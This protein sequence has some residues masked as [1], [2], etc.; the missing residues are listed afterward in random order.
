MRG[1]P[2]LLRQLC[3]FITL[4]Y[5]LQ[6]HFGA[7][8]GLQ[9]VGTYSEWINEKWA[10]VLMGTAQPGDLRAVLKQQLLR[11]DG[12][13]TLWCLPEHRSDLVPHA[14]LTFKLALTGFQPG[15]LH[16]KP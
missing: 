15:R 9:P 12:D 8:A 13:F 5:K 6:M 16:T 2:H 11:A 7:Q 10:G 3:L 1:H 4:R 14:C